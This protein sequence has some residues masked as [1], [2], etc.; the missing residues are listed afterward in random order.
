MSKEK[1]NKEKSASK[2]VKILT[3]DTETR[4]LFGEVFRVGLYDG[5]R[6]RATNTFKNLKTVL[7]QYTTKY[8]CHVFIHNLDFDISK[9]AKDI[10]PEADLKN[11]IFINN[12]VTVF[13]TG[14]NESQITEVNEII[15]Q[16][17]TF[18]D[19]SKLVM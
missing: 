2:P 17:I 15:S 7:S 10:L 6:Y 14:L 3:L 11:S 13:K 8:D 16:A 18:H 9:I 1:E 4:G 12:V 19:S 5:S